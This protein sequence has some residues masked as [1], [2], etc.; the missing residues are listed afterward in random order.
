MSNVLYDLMPDAVN[1]VGADEYG[2]VWKKIADAVPE[3][4]RAAR[5]LSVAKASIPADVTPEQIGVF[6]SMGI[7]VDAG[8]KYTM[9]LKD[10]AAPVNPGGPVVQG[11]KKAPDAEFAL[12]QML[13]ESDEDYAARL[14][15]V[16][17]QRRDE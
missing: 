15:L 10:E 17:Q 7:L 3:G 4:E 16:R 1:I 9:I 14:E 13:G 11:S 2:P 8:D 5:P 12:E 6:T